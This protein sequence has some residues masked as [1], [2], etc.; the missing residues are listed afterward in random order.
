MGVHGLTSFVDDNPQLL[1]DFALHDTKV[2]IDGNNLYHFLHYY[3]HVSHQYAGDYDHYADRVHYFFRTLHTCG[4]QPYV[5]F[6][7]SYDPE[8]RKLPTVLRR[9]RER[10]I[11]ANFLSKG[12]RGKILP[13]LAYE[14]FQNVLEERDI[15]YVVSDCE[16]DGQIAALAMRW[17]CPVLTNDSDFYIYDI[18]AGF[19]LLDYL[20]LQILTSKPQPNEEAYQY[21]GVQIYFLDTLLSQFDSL[22]RTMIPI[23]ATLLGNDF[24]DVRM[25]EEFYSSGKLPKHH[26]NQMFT[27][28]QTKMLKLLQWLESMSSQEEVLNNVLSH[29]KRDKREHVQMLLERSIDSYRNPQTNLE[30]F[31]QRSMECDCD[32]VETEWR[33]Y[34]GNRLPTWLIT[35]IRKGRVHVLMANAL[36]LHRVI[37]R[38]QVELVAHQS[39]YQCALPIRKALYRILLSL[40]L[41]SVE[42]DIDSDKKKLGYIE[43]YDREAK[44]LKKECVVPAIQIPTGLYLPSLHEITSLAA[45]K[46]REVLFSVLGIEENQIDFCSEPEKLFLS[47]LLYWAR[48]AEPRVNSKHLYALLVCFLKLSVIDTFDHDDLDNKVNR[49]D[50]TET[51]QQN[52]ETY[53]LKSKLIKGVRERLRKY[54]DPPTHSRVAVFDG[55]VIHVF[56]Q[57][58]TCLQASMHLNMLLL[59]PLYS[60]PPGKIYN[61]TFLYNLYRELKSRADPKLFVCELLGRGSEL[62]EHFEALTKHLVALLPVEFFQ[63]SVAGR[64]KTKKK[65]KRKMKKSKEERECVEE[66]EEDE[67]EEMVMKKLKVKAEC[68][69]TNKFGLLDLDN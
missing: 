52:N 44:H 43:E 4:V 29:V 17:N 66:D 61:G 53:A 51:M 7:G 22:S 6:D 64:K 16:A 3:L 20:N 41:D 28:K 46:R 59:N 60:L 67:E 24:V 58:Q 12:G 63:Q 65:E 15:P 25:F 39:A 42:H 34:K 5:V 56:C 62:A 33:T 55:G 48:T 31:L 36:I 2:I 26:N 57:I 49:E 37:L 69:L 45:Y 30:P 27:R 8:D 10:V 40:D 21:L 47:V 54:A 19:I 13:I 23:F 11:L 32:G 18:P 50:T 35:S 14:T 1:K 9:A 38:C 68:E